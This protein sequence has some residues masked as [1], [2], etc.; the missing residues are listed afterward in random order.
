[1]ER[2]LKI[3]FREGAKQWTD[4]LPIGNGRLGAMLWGGIS[5]ELIQL[6]GNVFQFQF[7]IVANAML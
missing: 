3:R 6:N 2:P 5:S 7:S 1:M 4:A